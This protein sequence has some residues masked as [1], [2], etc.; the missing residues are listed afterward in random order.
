MKTLIISDSINANVCE[1][2]YKRE[3]HEVKSINVNHDTFIMQENG[4]QQIKNKFEI[5]NHNK[6][7]SSDNAQDYYR[8]VNNMYFYFLNKTKLIKNESDI[9]NYNLCIPINDEENNSFLSTHNVKAKRK[10]E[11]NDDIVNMTAYDAYV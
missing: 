8:L 1:L 9:V 6:F 11:E 2:L 7:S 5:P 3:S 4:D 10:L